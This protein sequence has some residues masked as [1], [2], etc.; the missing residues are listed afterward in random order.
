MFG[1][2]PGFDSKPA[3]AVEADCFIINFGAPLV[4]ERGF[5]DLML[6]FG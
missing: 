3:D 6:G 4:E 1:S 5:R 2:I